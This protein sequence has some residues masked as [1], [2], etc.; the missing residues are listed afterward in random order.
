[1]ALTLG[2][3]QGAKDAGHLVNWQIWAAWLGI[4][5]LL[6]LKIISN[7]SVHRYLKM[8]LTDQI[9]RFVFLG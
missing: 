4:A 1:M 7:Y 2:T 3:W 8:N 6:Y 9:S 5:A